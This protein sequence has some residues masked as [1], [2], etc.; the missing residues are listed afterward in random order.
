MSQ[1]PA[2]QPQKARRRSSVL[3]RLAAGASLWFAVKAVSRANEGNLPLFLF[4]VFA[5]IFFLAQ[6]FIEWRRDARDRD[7]APAAPGG[8]PNGR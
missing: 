7:A 3:L 2:A 6:A 5:S 4:D 1:M 8:E